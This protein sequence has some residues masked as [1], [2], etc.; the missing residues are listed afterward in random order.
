MPLFP[1]TFPISKD[2]VIHFPVLE[3][4]ALCQQ[5]HRN[6]DILQNP[7]ILVLF[8]N[9][10][11]AKGTI[12]HWDYGKMIMIR[13]RIWKVVFVHCAVNL[14]VKKQAR[15]EDRLR[16]STHYSKTVLPESEYGTVLRQQRPV[17][18]ILLQVY[19]YAT[20]RGRAAGSSDWAA[21]RFAGRTVP[22]SVIVSNNEVTVALLRGIVQFPDTTFPAG[23]E[24]Y[25]LYSAC[26]QNRILQRAVPF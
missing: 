19:T 2:G 24:I 17:L 3:W 8:E 13:V 22:A 21:Q 15:T 1:P 25:D 5:R 20:E 6:F 14:R 23:R 11:S 4:A 7:L 9:A 18:L 10:V 12:Y 26:V 16:Y